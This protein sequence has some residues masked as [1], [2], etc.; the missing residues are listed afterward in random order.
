MSDKKASPSISMSKK[1]NWMIHPAGQ[2]KQMQI[3][4]A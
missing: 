1:Y 3:H 4:A 2:Q